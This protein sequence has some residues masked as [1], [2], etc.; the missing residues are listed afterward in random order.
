MST[1]VLEEPL[2]NVRQVAELLKVH[3]LTVRRYADGG[4]LESL[5]LPGGGFRFR[6]AAVEKMLADAAEN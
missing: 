6:R 5:R 3:P 2:L 4:H 1:A